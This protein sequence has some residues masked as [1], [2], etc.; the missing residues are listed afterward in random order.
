MVKTMK[1]GRIWAALAVAV[2][3]FFGALVNVVLPAYTPLAQA[4]DTGL[5]ID[6]V[7]DA[8]VAAGGNHTLTFTNSDSNTDFIL[9]GDNASNASPS[10]SAPGSAGQWWISNMCNNVGCNASHPGSIIGANLLPQNSSNRNGAVAFKQQVDMTTNWTLNFDMDIQKL[11]SNG[12]L[13]G[14]GA[15]DFLGFVLT[16]VSPSL[17]GTGQDAGGIGIAGLRNTYSWGID[18]YDNTSGSAFTS[19]SYD[20]ANLIANPG[21]ALSAQ[22]TQIMGFRHTDASGNLTNPNVVAPPNTF[23]EAS[24]ECSFN[25]LAGVLYTSNSATTN[26]NNNNTPY[27]VANATISWSYSGGGVGVLTAVMNSSSNCD[28]ANKQPQASAHTGQTFTYTV[29]LT[30]NSMSI[31]MAASDGGM[32]SRMG[33]TINSFTTQLGTGTTSVTYTDQ[34]GAQLRTPTSFIANTGEDI[35]IQGI[36]VQAASP[37]YASDDITFYAPTFPGYYLKTAPDVSVVSDTVSG[38]T[39]TPGNTMPLVYQGEYQSAST[40]INYP[41]DDPNAGTPIVL[42]ANG[43]SGRPFNFN[44][45]SAIPQGYHLQ[46]PAQATISG[47]YDTTENCNNSG[48]PQASTPAGCAAVTNDL[49]PQAFTVQLVADVQTLNINYTFPSGHD[50]SS[51]LTPGQIS[52]NS[53]TGQFFNPV[54]IPQIAG[55]RSSTIIAGVNGGQPFLTTQIDSIFADSTANGTST[56]DSVPQTVSVIYTPGSQQI[57]I[58]YGTPCSSSCTQSITQSAT[59][60]AYMTDSAYDAVPITQISGYT[61]MVSVN[62]ATAVP[63]QTFPAGSFSSTS[64]TLTVTYN[65]WLGT[66]KFYTVLQDASAANIGAITALPGANSSTFGIAGTDFAITFGSDTASETTSLQGAGGVP[67]GYHVTGSYWSNNPSGA[68]VSQNPPYTDDWDWS[69]MT[70]MGTGSAVDYQAAIVYTYTADV[71]SANVTTSGAPDGNAQG[72]TNGTVTYNGTSGG[73]QVVSVA[74]IPGYTVSVLDS[75]GNAMTVMNSQ[76]TIAYDATSNGVASTDASPQSFTITYAAVTAQVLVNYTYQT[77]TST[78]VAASASTDTTS[79]VASNLPNP[80]QINTQTG[81][82]YSLSIPNVAGYTWTV[83]DGTTSWTSASLPASFTSDGTQK[84]Y[85]VVYAAS[86]SSIT[87][88]YYEATYS[89][90]GAFTFTRNA[91]PGLSATVL[92]GAVG[93]TVNFAVNPTNIAVPSGWD[94]DPMGAALAQV[95][96]ATGASDADGLNG[97]SAAKILTLQVSPTSYIVYLARDIQSVQVRFSGAPNP[98][99]TIYADGRTGA[100]YSVPTSGFAIPGYTYVLT[101]PSGATVTQISGTYDATS[102]ANAALPLSNNGDG[103]ITPQVYNVAYTADF[104]QAVLQVDS[105]SPNGASVVETATGLTG[106]VL[107]FSTND[108]A[109]AIPGYTYQVQGPGGLNYSTLQTAL[110]A[111]KTFDATDNTGSSDAS[112]QTFTVHYTPSYQQAVLQTGAG[113]PYGSHV[114]E[115]SSG[116]TAGAISFTTTDA[117]LAL[118][119]YTYQI[120]VGATNYA[121]LAAALAANPSYDATSNGAASVDASPQDF[122]VNYTP[123]SQTV[124]VHYVYE[125]GATAAADATQTSVTNASGTPVASPTLPGYTPSQTSV[126]PSFAVNST[127]A[128]VTPSITVTYT[129]DPQTC[130]LSYEELG[131]ADIYQYAGS[132]PTL[133]SGK[134]GQI[135]LASAPS[136]P[137]YTFSGYYLNGSFTL[138]APGTLASVVYAAGSNSLALQ[139]TANPQ[140]VNIQYIYSS[141]DGSPTAGT[142]NVPSAALGGTP[143]PQVISG[144]TNATGSAVSSPSITGYTASQTSVTP[145]FAVNSTGALVTPTVTVT[146]SANAN[147]QADIS[148][149]D[150]SGTDLIPLLATH[151]TTTSYGTTGTPITS[152]GI[153]AVPGYSIDTIKYTTNGAD[154]VICSPGTTACTDST[155]LSTAVYSGRTSPV[156]ALTFEYAPNPQTV[157]VHY[158]Y[159]S[160]PRAGQ[161]FC[162]DSITATTNATSPASVTAGTLVGTAEPDGCSPVTP[163]GYTLSSTATQSI[164]WAVDATGALQTPAL[165]FY[166]TA[167]ATQANINYGTAA[168]ASSLNTALPSGTLSGLQNGTTGAVITNSGAVGIPGYTFAELQFNGAQVATSVSDANAYTPTYTATDVPS[169]QDELEFI[170]TPNPGTVTYHFV[171]GSGHTVYADQIATNFATGDTI[172]D[173]TGYT[174]LVPGFTYSSTASG[175][176]TT[177]PTSGIA[178]KTYVYTGDFQ[179]VSV[180]FVDEQDAAIKAAETINGTSGAAIN[181]TTNSLG[182]A[183]NYAIPGYTLSIDGRLTTTNFDTTNNSAVS[184]TS[185]QSVT[186][187]Y[188]AD[189]QTVNIYGVVGSPTGKQLYTQVLNGVTGGTIDYSHTEKVIPGYTLSTDGTQNP[190]N[191]TFNA[192]ESSDQNVYLI[193]TPDTQDAVLST[194]ASDPAGART[195]C[196][197]QGYTGAS[198]NFLDASPPC[199]DANLLHNGYSYTVTGPDDAQYANLVQAIAAN[200]F[201]DTTDNA[202]TPLPPPF[203]VHS[204]PLG[205]HSLAAGNPLS[206]NARGRVRSVLRGVSGTAYAPL[207][208]VATTDD[209]AAQEFL[210]SYTAN[211]Q[212]ALVQTVNDPSGNITYQV[213]TGLSAAPIVSLGVT[214]ADL[215]RD[216][217]TYVVKAPDGTEYATLADALSANPDFD[218]DDNANQVFDVVYDTPA[219]PTPNIQAPEPPPAGTPIPSDPDISGS[220]VG[221]CSVPAFDE[222]DCIAR[223]GEWTPLPNATSAGNTGITGVSRGVLLALLCLLVLLS[224]CGAHARKRNVL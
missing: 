82:T 7:T 144:T 122:T 65:A 198:I 68:V 117:A 60:S 24:Q 150:T 108:T 147:D 57:N 142:G 81:G 190:A 83:T 130:A 126:T 17:A 178:Q 220:P 224:A 112:V 72:V 90:S 119:G 206:E 183:I 6:N 161:D 176:S 8:D 129:P 185:I 128:L 215:A 202:P 175:S 45:S 103:D 77:D 222:Q 74:S 141:T 73:I 191:A 207:S 89:N 131:G 62:G 85:T 13:T 138:S 218:S 188:T 69:D 187:R 75:S 133:A 36:N 76:F 31:A 143:N 152:D 43:L 61:S 49:A 87:I 168:S 11:N 46:N 204:A 155:S 78:N 67:A 47:T 209:T 39:T 23:T 29:P 172:T 100:S 121:T 216:G 32:Y 9:S 125:G 197:V 186:M 28:T 149:T 86:Q 27:I 25:Q 97:G 38:S 56:T 88:N 79:Y 107:A 116:A 94:I 71:Q 170:Y 208:T 151:P 95:N 193:F 154:T 136:V 146:Y 54:S 217:Y 66:V 145:S 18:F 212:S 169:Y 120:Q 70:N 53:A 93:S 37:N 181:Y 201:F 139:Y 132:A 40:T 123:N 199:S 30:T 196:Q 91:V 115:T 135:I 182:S 159:A 111:N 162:T 114:V 5:S 21:G 16:P 179:Q 35:G 50:L 163:E 48:S 34:A 12:V 184:D 194:D 102:N 42:N 59:G 63:M 180:T 223:G 20:N 164:S 171:D 14:N 3:V 26:W 106:G 211:T 167:N 148:Y 80:V 157:E 134:T 160:G 177:M 41:A 55:Y 137:G 44:V 99:Q 219:V 174:T 205:A 4:V 22:P 96:D 192:D 113:D 214:D 105:S 92:S 124:T 140:S 118:P 173:F 153:I 210:V 52:Q 110:A 64:I 84:T 1:F 189:N 2:L 158:A 58:N 104:Q 221:T 165:Y 213:V 15:G 101:D 10:T 109:L 33:V 203:D 200:H 166:Y 156:D 51:T 98:P 127:G 195:I 19:P